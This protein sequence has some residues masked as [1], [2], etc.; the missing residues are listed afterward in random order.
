MNDMGKKGRARR[1]QRRKDKQNKKEMKNMSKTPH[2]YKT[3]TTTTWKGNNLSKHNCH[4][5]Q[6]KIFTTTGGVDVYGGG[7]NRDGGWW[8]APIVVDLA[9]GPDET[10]KPFNKSALTGGTIVPAGWSCDDH[11]GRIDPPKY[12][13]E[14]DFPDF[15]VPQVNKLFW[16]ALCDD[17]LEHG[18]KSISTQCA[19]GHGRT[20]VQLCILYYLLN[21][22][23]V[24]S[25][26]TDAAQLI[27]LIRDLHCHHAVETDGQQRYIA[28]VL[29]IPAGESKIDS[30][31]GG[32]GG[33]SFGGDASGKVGKKKTPTT[34][35]T[36]PTGTTLPKATTTT[37]KYD[38]NEEYKLP[39]LPPK[40]QSKALAFEECEC[41]GETDY[42]VDTGQCTSCGWEVPD[43]TA[44]PMLCYTCGKTKLP[45]D[46]LSPSDDTCIT[47][48]A[49]EMKV[50]HTDNEVQCSVCK[51]MR[52]TDMFSET[53][54]EGFICMAC[55]VKQ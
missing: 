39:P 32:W 3:T 41:C 27:E 50:K 47:C 19:G 40:P 44:E 35:T 25:T 7:R 36:T 43:P 34:K 20:G 21:D 42:N 38:L 52:Y 5:G 12:I 22:D 16:Y 30:S 31:Y 33:Y 4:T 13:I 17:I 8:K 29:D 24:K 1:A 18:I 11:T 6:K 10:M 37:G 26:I 49:D 45:H 48:L 2:N 28:N 15:G 53:T 9:M 46:Y 14:L 55:E 54:D 23:D 51:R